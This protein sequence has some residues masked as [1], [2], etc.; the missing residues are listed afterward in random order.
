M[1]NIGSFFDRFRNKVAGQVYNHSIVVDTIKKYTGISLDI[2]DIKISS[3][4][5][6]LQT[7]SL[8]K[9]EI[10]IKKDQILLDINNKLKNT[11]ISKIS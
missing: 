9:N 5:I 6:K 10:F 4:I 3:G 11:K 2:K 8:I 7:S 1:N